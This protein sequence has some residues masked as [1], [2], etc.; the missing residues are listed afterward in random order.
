MVKNN[1]L[2]EKKLSD[3]M[4][5]LKEELMPLLLTEE[6]QKYVEAVETK[7]KLLVEEKEKENQVL[8][9]QLDSQS[10]DLQLLSEQLEKVNEEFESRFSLLT[11]EK[12]VLE[13]EVEGVNAK[14]F[15]YELMREKFEL[16]EHYQTLLECSSKK[17]V[18]R[19]AKVVLEVKSS[20]SLPIKPKG[21]AVHETV[22]EYLKSQALGESLKF[23]HE[24][25]DE[26]LD[27]EAQDLNRLAGVE[28]T[29]EL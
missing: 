27:E 8:L 23:K 19:I 14:N 6:T 9:E 22:S 1:L 28:N 18:E 10:N 24:Y 2:T 17:E 26:P 13:R 5:L 20:N 16:R 3:V 25:V 11:E 29:K 4:S 21:L 7:A 12:L 15:A